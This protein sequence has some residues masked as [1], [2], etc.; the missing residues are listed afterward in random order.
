MS[1]IKL[2]INPDNLNMLLEILLDELNVKTSQVQMINNIKLIFNKNIQYFIQNISHSK[3]ALIQLNKEFLSQLISIVH[4]MFPQI[5]QEQQFKTINIGVETNNELHTIED[6]QHERKNH[7][8]EQ[9][10]NKQTE[11]NTLMNGHKPLE[12]NFA[13]DIK[14]DKIVEMQGLIADTIKNRNYDINQIQMAH[15][16]NNNNSNNN[17]NNIKKISWNDENN[18]EYEN[19]NKTE[20]NKL[21]LIDYSNNLITN[22]NISKINIQLL[23]LNTKIDNIYSLL[24]KMHETKCPQVNEII[25]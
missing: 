1:S 8:E 23:E 22:D 19:D 17:N 4:K 2:F 13:Y 14:D 24:L 15:V 25:S 3:K 20:T 9:Y 18:K 16:A 11:F 10:K 12:I 6:I 7:M 5:K 21:E